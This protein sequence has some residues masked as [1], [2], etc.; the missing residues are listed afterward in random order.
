VS[1][2]RIKDWEKFQ[3]Y[4][5]GPRADKPPEW[6]KLYPR[7]LNDLEFMKLDGDDAKVLMMLW[8]LASEYGGTL[9]SID[10]IAFRLRLSEKQIKSVLS[11][12][13]HWIETPASNALAPVYQTAS[14]EEEGELE[15]EVEGEREHT[16][17]SGGECEEAFQAYNET[18]KRLDLPLAENLSSQRRKKLRA[19]LDE[20]GL[21]GWFRALENLA[22]MPFCL[23]QGPRGWRADFDFLLQPSSFQKVLEKVYQQGI[24]P[25][26]QVTA[27]RSEFD[28]AVQRQLE[29]INGNGNATGRIE[30]GNDYPRLVH[31]GDAE[32]GRDA[33]AIDLSPGGSTSPPREPDG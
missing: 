2:Y 15:E 18:A 13:P 25:P 32:H 26:P 12:L 4:Q 19:R 33:G 17:P 30:S 11:R 28:R 22:E 6:I 7:L 20:H 5:S 27:K 10:K 16:P 8:M 14:P 29:K 21:P 9:P 3:H 31:S 24:G 1:G 23:G